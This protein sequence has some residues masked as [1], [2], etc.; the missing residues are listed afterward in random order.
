M[1]L[2]P[3]HA[4][5]VVSEKFHLSF[6]LCVFFAHRSNI[7]LQSFNVAFGLLLQ[8]ELENLD[9]EFHLKVVVECGARELVLSY[10][11][12]YFLKIQGVQVGLSCELILSGSV[13]N[14]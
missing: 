1:L 13:L 2:I 12:L 6:E 3:P 9:F 10:P 8:L 4:Q 11:S 7:L 14:S 5:E